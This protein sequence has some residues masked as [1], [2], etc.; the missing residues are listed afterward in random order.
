MHSC[1]VLSS[2]CAACPCPS[3][4]GRGKAPHSP[5]APVPRTV[6]RRGSANAS[7]MD[8]QPWPATTTSPA[9]RA[10]EV[11]RLPLVSATL[12]K[13]EQTAV[14]TLLPADRAP[15]L[16]AM[17][18][19]HSGRARARAH[20][21]RHRCPGS[22]NRPHSALLISGPVQVSSQLLCSA[23]TGA[24]ASMQVWRTWSARWLVSK[25]SFT[26]RQRGQGQRVGDCTLMLLPGAGYGTPNGKA[27]ACLSSGA[28]AVATRQSDLR[29][30]LARRQACSFTLLSEAF[31]T[32]HHA[33]PLL[34]SDL[35][36]GWETEGEADTRKEWKRQENQSLGSLQCGKELEQ[37]CSQRGRRVRPPPHP[38]PS[39]GQNLTFK[40]DFL[41]PV[42]ENNGPLPVT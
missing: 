31:P 7:C 30:Q 16:I 12:Q 5:V 3:P 9:P 38:H 8:K 27:T 26:A 19:R 10:A 15:D 28:T 42:K 33:V 23:K 24:A 11:H 21:T 17:R 2:P 1:P 18:T 39:P 13:P 29:L 6:L 37:R 40:Q 14:Q 35:Q 20:H 22:R 4:A 41:L 36:R 34:S 25:E 32:H